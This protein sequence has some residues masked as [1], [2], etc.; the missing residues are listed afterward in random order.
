MSEEIKE[1]IKEAILSDCTVI[2][3]DPESPEWKER[4]AKLQEKLEAKRGKERP[5]LVEIGYRTVT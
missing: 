3:V 2:K 5:P 1:E 4:M